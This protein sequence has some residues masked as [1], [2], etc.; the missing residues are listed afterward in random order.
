[1]KRIKCFFGKHSFY[2]I[3]K[4]SINTDKIGC[5]NCGKQFAMN[6]DVKAIV[7]WDSDFDH[8]YAILRGIERKSGK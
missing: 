4:M 2:I 5:C 6:H 1:M 3:E 7:P 8:A